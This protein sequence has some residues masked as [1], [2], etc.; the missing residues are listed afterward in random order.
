MSG[1]LASYWMI[2]GGHD[3]V[4]GVLD[5]ASCVSPIPAG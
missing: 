3:F 4:A 2:N 1:E 5:S